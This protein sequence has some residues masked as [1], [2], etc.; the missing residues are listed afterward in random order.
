MDG[1]DDALSS[2]PS[3]LVL[4]ASFENT[5]CLFFIRY[6][7]EDTVN[8]RWFLVQINQLETAHFKMDPSTSDNYCVTF[9]SRHPDDNHLCDDVARWWLEWH[10][11]S[12]NDDNILVYG[13][14]M[15]F[16]PNRKPNLSK[17]MLWTDSIHL[18][19]SSCYIH[20]PFNFDSR[21]DVISAKQFVTLRHWKL[22]LTSIIALGIVPPTIST[23]TQAK[24]RKRRKHH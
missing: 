10:E 6:L 11:Y 2:S 7:P 20:G 9:L 14:R 21:S 4:H 23:L 19:D 1:I 12:L 13:S 24:P 5:D 17:F 22:L 15:L 16:K 18:S 8:P 3:P